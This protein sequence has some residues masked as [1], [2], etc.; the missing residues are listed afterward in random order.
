MLAYLY[1]TRVP[2]TALPSDYLVARQQAF[3]THESEESDSSF[4]FAS[5]QLWLRDQFYGLK[6]Q[7]DWNGI[8]PA[9]AHAMYR[10]ADCYGIEEL[11][12][13]A[14]DR[15]LRSLTVE[16]VGFNLSLSHTFGSRDIR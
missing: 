8:E 6:D 14:R 2:F 5:P 9:S 1:T 12:E 16:N 3:E 7:R 11:R 4:D 15:I 13:L 10:L